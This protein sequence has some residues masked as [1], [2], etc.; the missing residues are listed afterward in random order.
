MGLKL[1]IKNAYP[2]FTSSEKAIAD[3]FLKNAKEIQN[4]STQ[5]LGEKIGTSA[6]TIVRF[7]RTLGYSGFPALKMDLMMGFKSDVPDLTSDLKQ[8]ESIE[9][10]VQTTYQH[11]LKNLENTREMIDDDAIEEA[12]KDILQCRVVYLAGVAGSGVVCDD[13]HQ[14]LNRIGITAFFNKDIHVQVASLAGIKKEDVLIAVSYNG[15]TKSVLE[16]AHIAKER[17]AKVIGISKLGKT[18]LSK[19]ANMMFY[20][21]VQENSIRAGAVASRDS[22]LFITD[23]IYLSLFSRNLNHSKEILAETKAWTSKI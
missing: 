12:V 21:P 22:S 14:K 16:C 6:A 15:E 7:S 23:L 8:G 2:S 4:C 1:R 13:F 11:R 3:Y 5:E 9:A 19:I 20:L 10:L 18:S 17:N